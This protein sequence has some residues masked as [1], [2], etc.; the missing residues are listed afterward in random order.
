VT[1]GSRIGLAIVHPRWALAAAGDRKHPG[2]SGSDL[3]AAIAL[4]LVATQLAGIVAG[5][6]LGAVVEWGL[7]ARALV[8]LLTQTLAVDLGFLVVGALILFGAAGPR[9]ELGRAFDLACVAAL[10]LVLV[11]LTATTVV[12]SFDLA[13][14]TIAM[15][16]LSGIA[17]AWTGTLVALAIPEARAQRTPGEPPIATVRGARIAGLAAAAI[18]L[19]GTAV[20]VAWIARNPDLIRPMQDGMPAPAIALHAIGKDGELGP[21]TSL[22]PGK[23]TVL[24]FWATWCGPCLAA[25]PRLDVVA[26]R[27]PEIAVFAINVDD[28]KAA[29]ALFDEA[30]YSLT[31]LADD[32]LTSQRY[33]VKSYPHTVII[34]RA[35]FVKVLRGGAPDL[36]AQVTSALQK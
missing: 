32:G 20:Q 5:V 36:E 8:D 33:G 21:V 29:R 1:I 31:L 18:A 24:D 25:M 7:G 19:A 27:H 26:R 12:R 4:L 11:D 16:T 22:P 23:V 28:A 10:P 15:W 3:L 14:P 34:D 35:G 2:R 13:V 30:G 9:R 6:W 17:Y